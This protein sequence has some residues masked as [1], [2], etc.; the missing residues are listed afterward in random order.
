MYSEPSTAVVETKLL[1]LPQNFHSTDKTYANRHAKDRCPRC[2]SHLHYVLK[3]GRFQCADCE[4]IWG[5]KIQVKSA[6]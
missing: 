4:K 6:A 5:K 3:D 1:K 2:N